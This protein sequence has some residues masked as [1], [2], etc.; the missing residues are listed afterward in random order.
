MSNETSMTLCELVEESIATLC[1]REGIVANLYYRWSKE[2]LEAGKKR[3]LGDTKRR[4]GYWVKEDSYTDGEGHLILRTKKDGDRYTC[5]AIRTRGKF[6]HRYGYWVCRCKFPKEPGHWPAFWMMSDGVGKVGNGG[7][8]GTEIDI[9]EIP[10]RD[11]KMPEVIRW[12]AEGNGGAVG[13]HAQPGVRTHN[14]F[15]ALDFHWIAEIESA[16]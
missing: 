7:C 4:D 3:L 14:H 9:V 12:T 5:G 13:I 11:G 10:W 8:D 16:V 1:R 6:E 15:K 2:F